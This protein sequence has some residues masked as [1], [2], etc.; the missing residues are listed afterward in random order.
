MPDDLLIARALHLLSLVVWFG[1]V[2]FVALV[3]LPLARRQPT[4]EQKLALFEGI[5]RPF[6]RIARWSV[7]LAGLSGLWMLRNRELWYRFA[8]PSFWWMWAMVALWLVF[9]LVLYV[10]EPLWLHAAFARWARR[11]AA[12]AFAW[13]QRLHLLL[14]LAGAITI[15]GAVAGSH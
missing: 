2:A 1:G 12:A 11:D 7:A 14:L 5:E 10:A 8:E 15:A 13:A 3:V 4:V 9:A 6:G